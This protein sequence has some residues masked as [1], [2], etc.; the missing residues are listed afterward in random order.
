MMDNLRL[1]VIVAIFI[2]I[3]VVLLYLKSAK[4]GRKT[5]RKYMQATD[6]YDRSSKEEIRA[7]NG[8]NFEDILGSEAEIEAELNDG[9]GKIE[10]MLGADMKDVRAEITT[11]IEELILKIGEG[12]KEVINKVENV[13]DKKV[14]EVLSKINDRIDEVL[15]AQKDSTALVLEKII[16]SLRQK[17]EPVGIKS[18]KQSKKEV[19]QK[20][21]FEEI[22]ERDLDVP[23]EDSDNLGMLD[24]S[25]QKEGKS[26]GVSFSDESGYAEVVEE[27]PEKIKEEDLEIPF[28]VS[29]DIKAEAEQIASSE[30]IEK[31]VLE[32]DKADSADFDIQEFLEELE[33]LPSEQDP[34]VEK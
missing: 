31:N 13:I 21:E 5:E 19:D 11:K 22:T 1:I 33:N 4:S 29:E 10:T 28:E 24:S 8:E 18:S 9:D 20:V 32:V 7:K 23:D 2:G 14:Q 12:E 34:E 16:D 6:P 26:V 17:E 30:V 15:Q 27:V 25:L 3:I